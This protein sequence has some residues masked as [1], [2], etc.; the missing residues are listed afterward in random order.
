MAKVLLALDYTDA[1]VLQN[2][3]NEILNTEVEDLECL[4]RVL[5]DLKTGIA[6]E[7]KHNRSKFCQEMR[8][9]LSD[10]TDQ[11]P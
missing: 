6:V 4:N 11:E 2:H 10:L 1:L 5:L 3:I 7:Q 8:E 9:L